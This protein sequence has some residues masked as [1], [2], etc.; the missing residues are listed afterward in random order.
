MADQQAYY[1]EEPIDLRYYLGFVRTVWYRFYRW[2]I[3][4]NL[5]G[6]TIAFLHAQAQAPSFMSTV[7]LH[8]APKDQTMFNLEQV[9]WGNNDAG[10]KDTQ[11]GILRSNQLLRTVVEEVGLHKVDYLTAGAV[12][13]GVLGQIK[14]LL[15]PRES[16]VGTID[17][18]TLIEW[19]ATEVSGL[20]S[21]YESEEQGF[22]NLLYVQVVMADPDLAAATANSVATIYVESVFEN[23]LENA[24]KNQKFLTERLSVLRTQLREAEEELNRFMESE[25][26]VPRS[27]GQNDVDTELDS[28]T[29]RY[30]ELSK[31]RA[32]IENVVQQAR[33]V[34]S[35]GAN[36][37]NV[38]AVSSHPLVNSLFMQILDLERRK[39]ELSKRY[40]SRHN[41]MIAIESELTTA[42]RALQ[43]QVGS[44]LRSLETEL[45]AASNAE[46]VVQ[47]ALN[48]VRD[49]KQSIG[50]KGYRL[51]ELQQ[52]IAVKQQVYTAFLE[53][54]NRDDASGPIRNTNVWVA[55]PA[56]VPRQG[57]S[58]SV[59]SSIV[60]GLVLSTL[61]SFGFGIFIVASNNTLQTE[62]DVT[63]KTS[64]QL[65]GLL[66]IVSTEGRASDNAPFS[67]YLENLH[68]RF[69]EAIRSVRTTLTLM[70]VDSTISRILVTSCET[71]EG[72][73]SIALS[74]SASL[75]QTAS[76]LLVDADL[77]RP[78]VE[79]AITDHHHKL[80]GVADVLAG[81][82]TIKEAVVHHDAANIDILPA[83]SR[84][85]K[86]LELL[87][88]AQF[89]NLLNELSDDY[90]YVIVDSP[91]CGAVSDSYLL[92]SLTDT[93]LFVVKAHETP[94][95]TVRSVLHKFRDLDVSVAGIL[96]NQVDFESKSYPY[97]KDY[98]QYDG[99]GASDKPVSL[100]DAV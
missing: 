53:K 43:Q 83:G 1:E 92:G 64:A 7:T 88:S 72:K 2:I 16:Q 54:L 74:L 31:E 73:T 27:T 62:E 60:T 19:R 26:I 51:N 82:V 80:L 98:A 63:E 10:F 86:P 12:R 20:M 13:I 89:T 8:I 39:G 24:I 55:D 32:R 38:P 41:K 14:D 45:E 6:I 44:V 33:S 67:E 47:S 52:D 25:N 29:S 11:I 93:V 100:N 37:L 4:V 48:E 90:D 81:G 75:G 36:L 40:G 79:K 71:H 35:G 76:V 84:S 58:S 18:E 17:E 97:Y 94:A 68:S 46:A 77:R 96:L 95:S 5:I 15:F 57:T 85:L 99:Y 70:N 21:I 65:L 28:V 42:N 87:G 91:P 3:L 50:R 22:S 49:K 61:L 59:L 23:E 69:S 9:F 78:S 34:Q 66:P 30:F 56:T